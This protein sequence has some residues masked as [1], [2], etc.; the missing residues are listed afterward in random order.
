MATLTEILTIPA[1]QR[2]L[3]RHLS[4]AG[5][6]VGTVAVAVVSWLAVH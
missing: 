5:V 3:A 6:A 4:L 1:V 2:R